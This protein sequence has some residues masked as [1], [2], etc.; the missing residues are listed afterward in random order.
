MTLRHKSILVGTKRKVSLRFILE[1]LKKSIRKGCKLYDFITMNNKDVIV[2]V[3][4]HPVLSKF[5]DV[6]PEELPGLP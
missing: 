3:V 4:Q 5:P 6:F 2:N 1:F